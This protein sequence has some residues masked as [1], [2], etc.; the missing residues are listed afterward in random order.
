MTLRKVLPVIC[1]ALLLSGCSTNPVETPLQT[2]PDN[3]TVTESPTPAPTGVPT[4]TPTG[5][6]APTPAVTEAAN[7]VTPTPKPTTS[8]IS[9]EAP[10]GGMSIT[11]EELWEIYGR[12]FFRVDKITPYEGDFLVQYVYSEICFDWVYG[13]TG[14]RHRIME[15]GFG[16]SD[17]E[18]LEPGII[19]VLTDGI[20]SSNGYRTFPSLIKGYASVRLDE[21]GKPLPYERETGNFT[22]DT[23]W[24]DIHEASSFGRA[25][26]EAVTNALIDVTGAQFVFGPPADFNGLMAFYTSSSSVPVTE[27]TFDEVSRVMTL[28]FRD[29]SLSSGDLPDFPNEREERQYRESLSFLGLALPTEFPAGE[30][31]GSN[32]FISRATIEESGGDTVATLYLTEK[33]TEYTVEAGK[34]GPMDS[35]P[36][37]RFILRER[38]RW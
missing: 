26:R 4:H 7:P 10:A 2:G 25:R 33:A 1:C 17:V 31:Y 11:E 38:G 14:E 24:A 13:T 32:P 37:I 15:C 36:Y 23:Y 29:T 8:V 22:I 19:R 12:E 18:I 16:V 20:Y 3:G 34:V 30:L 35:G 28:T 27:I 6:G 21:N 5:S 9:T